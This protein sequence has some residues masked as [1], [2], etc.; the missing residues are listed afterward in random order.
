MPAIA[1]LRVPSNDSGNNCGTHC[2]FRSL[3]GEWNFTK[4]QYTGFSR[5]K[6]IESVRKSS[7]QVHGTKSCCDAIIYYYYLPARVPRTIV[8]DLNRL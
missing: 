2:A 6:F 1:D 3:L 7:R 8:Q 4:K 5:L